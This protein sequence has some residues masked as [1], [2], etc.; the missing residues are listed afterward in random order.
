[1]TLFDRMG[2]GQAGLDLRG[3]EGRSDSHCI[4]HRCQMVVDTA[5][6]AARLRDPSSPWVLAVV[7]VEDNLEELT[8]QRAE[9]EEA[10]T[11]ATGLSWASDGRIV[12]VQNVDGLVDEVAHSDVNREGYAGVNK[13]VELVE[14]VIVDYD[15]LVSMLSKKS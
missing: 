4:Q 1:M 8:A 12:R 6:V 5:V 2:V 7:V 11:N 13:E 14:V 9:E 15:G 10:H 3:E